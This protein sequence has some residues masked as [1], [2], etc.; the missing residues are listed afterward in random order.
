[1]DHAIGKALKPNAL[2][3]MQAT[4]GQ[5]L[6]AEQ[7]KYAAKGLGMPGKIIL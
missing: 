1:M 3:C 4:L 2:W 6:L 5:Q 7:S